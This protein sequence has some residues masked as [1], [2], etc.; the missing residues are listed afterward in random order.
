M[1]KFKSVQKRMDVFT[2]RRKFA[3]KNFSDIGIE[4]EKIYINENLTPTTR[5]LFYH[6]NTLKK[7]HKW[8]YIWTRNGNI[9]LR[10][11]DHTQIVTIKNIS[12]LDK[13]TE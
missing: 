2:N 7:T 11:Y 5:S 1:V 3:G 4:T 6:A 13:I 8:K 9:K 10:K 12:D